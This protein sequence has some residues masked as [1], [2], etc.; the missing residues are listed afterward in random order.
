MK[1]WYMRRQKYKHRAQ[2]LTRCV[3]TVGGASSQ[4]ERVLGGWWW[5]AIQH[6]DF[7]SWLSTAPRYQWT[8]YPDTGRTLSWYSAW[9]LDRSCDSLIFPLIEITPAMDPAEEQEEG[10]LMVISTLV[11]NNYKLSTKIK[12]TGNVMLLLYSWHDFPLNNQYL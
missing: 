8:Q 11:H 2:L 12:H 10:Q 4:H 1:L 5:R 6:V 3:S 9:P 7:I